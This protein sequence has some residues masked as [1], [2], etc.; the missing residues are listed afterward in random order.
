MVGYIVINERVVRSFVRLSGFVPGQGQGPVPSARPRSN[1][2][3]SIP[4]LTL[5]LAVPVLAVLGGWW[6]IPQARAWAD[7]PGSVPPARASRGT[8]YPTQ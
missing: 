6:W 8:S 7:D 2:P 5:T 4:K 1:R 3:A